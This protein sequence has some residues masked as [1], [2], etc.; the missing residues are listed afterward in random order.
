MTA[1]MDTPEHLLPDADPFSPAAADASHRRRYAGFDTST[2]S[3]YS[4]GSPTQTK[5]A[6]EA[7]LAETER[8]LQEASQLGSALVRQ[9]SELADK[10]KEVQAHHDEE[11]IGPELRQ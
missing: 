11:D 9:R 1:V 7:H 3:L 5:R 4:N 6:L 2:F 8:R 10:L